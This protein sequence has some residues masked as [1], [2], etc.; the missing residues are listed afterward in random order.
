MLGKKWIPDSSVNATIN[1]T[2]TG[3]GRALPV[4]DCRQAEWFTVYVVGAEPTSGSIIIEHAPSADYAGV[5][6]LL[7]Q[8]LAADVVAGTGGYGTWPGPIAF[9]RGRF[10]TAAD[11]AVTVYING[12]L[13]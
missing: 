11:Q 5:W 6:N 10:A 13:S 2:T 1:N 12:L 4:N 7:D 3:T 8:F 9:V